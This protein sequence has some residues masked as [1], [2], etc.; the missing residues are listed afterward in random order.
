MNP[1]RSVVMALLLSVIIFAV[2]RG[3]LSKRIVGAAPAKGA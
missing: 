3:E 1:T 2:A